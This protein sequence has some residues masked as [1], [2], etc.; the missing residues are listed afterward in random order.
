MA[1]GKRRKGPTLDCLGKQA[2]LQLHQEHGVNCSEQLKKFGIEAPAPA[3][4]PR[5]HKFNV[6]PKDQRTLDG[7]V[8]DSKFEMNAYR[9]LRDRN[10]PFTRQPR[11][12]LQEGFRDPVSGKRVREIAYEGDFLLRDREG[13]EFIVDT[14]G[15]RTEVFRV[16]EK[17]MLNQGRRVHCIKNLKAL[18]QFLLEHGL[19]DRSPLQ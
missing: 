13:R 8:F 4:P 19:L 11:F 3:A 1:R 10:I 14:K 15:F 17:M 16:K 6:S 2:L 7:I 9:F 18:V 5:A 12:V